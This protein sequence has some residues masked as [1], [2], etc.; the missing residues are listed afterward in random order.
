MSNKTDKVD[1]VC[2][3]PQVSVDDI[4]D[5]FPKK[6]SDFL[7]RTLFNLSRL[8]DPPF[9]GIR[10]DLE[11]DC[12]NLFTPDRERS[13][14]FLRELAQQGFIRFNEVEAGLQLN[15]FF[16]TTKF[17]EKVEN[18]KIKQKSRMKQSKTEEKAE[19]SVL[20]MP[21]RSTND[22]WEDIKSAYDISKRDFGKKINFVSDSFKRKIIFRDVEH[23]FVLAS[24]G[25]SKPALILAGGVI[26]ELLRLYLEHNRIKPQGKM[27]VDYIKACED[28][29]LLKRGVS[30]LTD[31]IRDFRNLV[32]LGNEKTK[33]Y[34]I[35][36]ATAKGS[37]ASIFTIANDFQK[38]SP[39]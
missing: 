30:R 31:S 10:L 14:A 38:V 21:V 15:F 28:N 26:E 29:G 34:T 18:L 13:Y 17:W 2:G 19:G 6:A 27:F 16:L 32:H 1:K 23:A 37:V 20:T 39:S 12:L 9:E 36:K 5:D 35:S 22:N 8:A 33:R 3:Y 7:N 24:E 11:I 25:F 4:L